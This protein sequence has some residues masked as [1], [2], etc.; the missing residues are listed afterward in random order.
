MRLDGCL[1]KQPYL[2]LNEFST[3]TAGA[4][5]EVFVING[6]QFHPLA[7]SAALGERRAERRDLRSGQW[8]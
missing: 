8:P 5:L 7:V 2:L 1:H 3:H 6:R 4:P